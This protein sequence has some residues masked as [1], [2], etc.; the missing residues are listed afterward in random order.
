M[1]THLETN[2]KST[3]NI[4]LKSTPMEKSAKT[5]SSQDGKRQIIFLSCEC[6]CVSE[7]V[8]VK[9]CHFYIFDPLPRETERGI[10]L[11]NHTREKPRK[12][13]THIRLQLLPYSPIMFQLWKYK[14][15]SLSSPTVH[16]TPPTAYMNSKTSC[17][18]IS[19]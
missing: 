18:C 6:T 5:P 9:V 14:T 16:T 8:C 4:F 7:S 19:V 10:L 3:G 2:K 12:T 1:E 11:L 13:K 15:W 17:L